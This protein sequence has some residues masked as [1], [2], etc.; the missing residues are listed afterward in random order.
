MYTHM[1][2][3]S[4]SLQTTVTLPVI[5]YVIIQIFWITPNFLPLL[6]KF[7]KG[8]DARTIGVPGA[9]SDRYCY[10]DGVGVVV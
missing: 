6:P 5:K 4:A 9:N 2:R 10:V 1:H 3:K 7:T 8:K